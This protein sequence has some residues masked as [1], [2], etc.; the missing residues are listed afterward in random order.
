MQAGLIGFV[1]PATW[2]GSETALD[3]SSTF[4]KESLEGVDADPFGAS[5]SAIMVEHAY[6]VTSE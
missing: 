6:N 4:L 5:F 2:F 3:I 1:I